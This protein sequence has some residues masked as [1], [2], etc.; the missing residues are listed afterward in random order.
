M[1]RV[2]HLD[3]VAAIQGAEIKLNGCAGEIKKKT[4]FENV[5]CRKEG[6]K[7]IEPPYAPWPKSFESQF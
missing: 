7:E 1:D 5:C 6:G 3:G 2:C 4:K